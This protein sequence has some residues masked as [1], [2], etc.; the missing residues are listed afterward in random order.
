[1]PREDLASLLAFA[2]RLADAADATAL[3]HFRRGV[4]VATKPDRTLVTQ[5]DT[6]IEAL[7]RD[8]IADAYPDHGVLGEELG[9]DRGR[10]ETLWVI[11]PID[12][13]H[14]FARGIPVFATLIGVERAGEAVLGLVSAPALRERW[15]AARG[16]GAHA[17]SGAIRVSAVEALADAQIVYSSLR[18]AH[19]TGWEDGL[20]R[21]VDAAWR[22][23]G[24]GDFWGHVLVAQGSAEAMLETGLHPW[25]VVAP[26]AIVVEAGGRVTDF[27]GAPT[28]HG[29]EVLTT[30]GALHEKLL[31]LLAETV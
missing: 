12:G 4:T 21:I 16:G 7:I 1:M 9:D 30:N 25:D 5:A 24:F 22:D 8:R 23:R 27:R 6:E 28:I 29:P 13:T 18:R 19:A 2:H 14:N 11:D 31:E 26:A 15:H 3:R 10:A 17:T 20:R